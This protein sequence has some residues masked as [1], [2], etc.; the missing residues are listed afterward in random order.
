MKKED[1]PAKEQ[2]QQE[3]ATKKILIKQD[4]E[5]FARRG[6]SEKRFHSGAL[7]F[8]RLYDP[9][10][11]Y[12]RYIL[13]AAIGIIMSFFSV[14]LVQSTGLYTGGF[15]AICQG[16]AR[17]V[18]AS[19][20]KN[21]NGSHETRLVIYNLL[22]WGLYLAINVPLIVFAYFKINK[23]FAI[24]SIIYLVAMQG[25]GF[26]WGIIPQLQQFKLFGLTNSIYPMLDSQKVQ[27]NIF[28][29]HWYP[30][31]GGSSEWTIDWTKL[32]TESQLHNIN[33]YFPPGLR[34]D[35]FDQSSANARADWIVNFVTNENIANTFL[36][37]LYC[38]V[39]AIISSLGY[40]LVYILGGS[41]GGSDFVT[42]YLSQEK[43]KNVG[44]MFIIINLICMLIGITIGSYGAGMLINS[45][46]FSGWEFFFSANLFV[47]MLF[48]I[49][50]GTL[51]NKWFPW[52]K[53]TKVEIYSTKQTEIINK[54]KN[55]NYTHPV[56]VVDAM[57]GMSGSKREVMITICMM[58]E[59]PKLVHAIRT[60]DPDCLISSTPL[61]DLDG[62]F[63]LQ[64]QTF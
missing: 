30:I 21:S 54:L 36:L 19:L 2:K 8:K 45:K 47:S 46:Y 51:M 33:S 40:A 48:I 22:F 16:I 61:N 50:N 20:N 15:G 29:P 41:T 5:R 28:Y 37:L 38:F 6:V 18:Y 44:L 58:V 59:L 1:N 56:T 39:Y 26:V 14:L 53:T 34:P 9:K 35:W 10:N 25:M 13:A 57:G 42:I 49:L 24:L 62:R 63:T 17:L 55:I 27:V 11:K 7:R 12:T 64:R 3:S 52:H 32:F 4:A 60:V 31:I 23:Q 43:N